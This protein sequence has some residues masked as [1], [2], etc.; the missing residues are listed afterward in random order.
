MVDDQPIQLEPNNV[1]DTYGGNL[2][3]HTTAHIEFDGTEDSNE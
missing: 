1:N 2:Q 3:Y